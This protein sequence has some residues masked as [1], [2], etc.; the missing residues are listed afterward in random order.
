MPRE[1]LIQIRRG[2]GLE[3]GQVDPPVLEFGEFAWVEDGF[4][5]S[6]GDLLI[7]SREG[8]R[9]VGGKGAARVFDDAVAG[10]APTSNLG[11]GCI[12]V[13]STDPSEFRGMEDHYIWIDTGTPAVKVWITDAWVTVASVAA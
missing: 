11:A 7:G 5:N 9:I 13:G 8:D 1:T 2:T 4:A 12:F 6:D 3:W 10:Y